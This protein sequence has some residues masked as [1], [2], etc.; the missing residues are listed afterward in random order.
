MPTVVNEVAE[1]RCRSMIP[2]RTAEAS[3]A[4]VLA[5]GIEEQIALQQLELRADHTQ[6]SMYVVVCNIS[7][8]LQHL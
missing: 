2:D 4:A 8:L 1:H 5:K 7:Q 3:S 6:P